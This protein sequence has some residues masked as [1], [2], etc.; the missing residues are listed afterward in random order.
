MGVD[1]RPSQWGG[2]LKPVTEGRAEA[3]LFLQTCV[4]LPQLLEEAEAAGVSRSAGLVLTALLDHVINGSCFQG[5]PS[6]QYFVDFVFRLHSS[7]PPNITL[8]GEA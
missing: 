3:N 8:H 4:D 6:P 5:L 1:G 7:D 2:L